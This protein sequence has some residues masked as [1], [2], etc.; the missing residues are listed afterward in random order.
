[1][2]S[3]NLLSVFLIA[4][5]LAMDAFSV[6]LTKGFTQKHLTKTQILYYGLF[7]GFFQFMMPVIDYFCISS[8]S[9][10]IESFASI[11]GFVLLL[12]IGLNMIRESLFGG[13]EEIT[14]NFSFRE[15]ILLAIAT[16]IDA[17]AVGITFAVLENPF[18]MPSIIIGVVAFAFSIAGIY[19]GRRLGDYFGDKFQILGGVILILIG[20]KI[21]LGF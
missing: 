6:S 16:S 11:I 5:A 9:S 19:I 7:F 21:L 2:M 17:F 10:I 15:V 12:G 13:D 4:V 8:I 14:D 1:M 20:I 18:L 3:L